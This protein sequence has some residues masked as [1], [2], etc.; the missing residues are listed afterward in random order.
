MAILEGFCGSS[1]NLAV[2][3]TAVSVYVTPSSSHSMASYQFSFSLCG[4]PENAVKLMIF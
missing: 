2:S 3:L 1:E 4:D